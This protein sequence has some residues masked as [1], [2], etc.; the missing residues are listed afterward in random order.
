MEREEIMS[1]V[2]LLMSID[3]QLKEVID[4]LEH[5]RRFIEFGGVHKVTHRVD[6][7]QPKPENYPTRQQQELPS[8][9]WT[10]APQGAE[11]SWDRPVH[12]WAFNPYTNG[13]LELHRRLTAYIE[14]TTKELQRG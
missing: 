9:K 13:M 8:F 12:G 2:A 14:A 11:P 1:T 7:D 10:N 5:H 3:D 6:D 4:G